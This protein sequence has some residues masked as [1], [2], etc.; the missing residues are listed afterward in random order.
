MR[1]QK[2]MALTV[3]CCFFAGGFARPARA[4]S[5][6]SSFTE[7]GSAVKRGHR[8]SVTDDAGE[9]IQGKLTSLSPS[10]I[11]LLIDGKATSVAASRVREVTE[12]RRQTG[13]GARIGL[14]AGAGLGLL[15]GLTVEDCFGCPGPGGTAVAGAIVLGGLG[16][17]IG[18]IIGSGITRERLVY[19]SGARPPVALSVSPL[20]SPLGTGVRA[21]VRF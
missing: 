5:A 9:R 11:E 15:S 3:M 20:A 13:R 17:G 14:A 12:L 2:A 10:A 4:Q 18:A 6:A 7:I 8:V 16:A 21:V 1:F 19:R